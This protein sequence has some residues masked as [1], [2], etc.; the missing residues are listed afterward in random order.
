MEESY[1]TLER[2]V[3]LSFHGLSDFALLECRVI[4]AVESNN[5]FVK[6]FL[7]GV[8]FECCPSLLIRVSLLQSFK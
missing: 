8:P 6:C 5:V 2:P 4:V 3:M 7:V 1:R